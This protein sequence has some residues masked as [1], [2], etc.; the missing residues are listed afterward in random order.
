MD[1]STRQ[2]RGHESNQRACPEREVRA[3]FQS[4]Q[5]TSICG[6]SDIVIIIQFCV[7]HGIINYL[8]NQSIIIITFL[9]NIKVMVL[10]PKANICLST[11]Q[12]L[13]HVAHIR[14]LCIWYCGYWTWKWTCET[15]SCP[16]CWYAMFCTNNRWWWWWW[17]LIF[18]D[19]SALPQRR[20]KYPA[21]RSPWAMTAKIRMTMMMIHLFRP[22]TWFHAKALWVPSS[23]VC[24]V[25]WCSWRTTITLGALKHGAMRILFCRFPGTI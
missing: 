9:T 14:T 20:K 25:I 4:E 17:W 21:T 22:C 19:T 1:A 24:L 5:S 10:S 2:E 23:V 16:S 12:Y 18:I 15:A 7:I 8:I 13:R 11:I 3:Q 6:I